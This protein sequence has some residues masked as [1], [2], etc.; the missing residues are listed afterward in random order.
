LIHCDLWTSPIVSVSGYKYTLSFLM[1]DC[2]PYV[3]K[4]TYRQPGWHASL[5]HRR[6]ITS[7]IKGPTII[8][9]C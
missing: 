7:I 8:T 2:I 6:G 5:P 3:Y 1:I 9:L 4:S